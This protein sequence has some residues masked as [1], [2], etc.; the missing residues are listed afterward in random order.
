MFLMFSGITFILRAQNRL[1]R[2]LNRFESPMRHWQ[3][4]RNIAQESM[5]LLSASKPT[6]L[7][8]HESPCVALYHIPNVHIFGIYIYFESIIKLIAQCALD[9]HNGDHNLAAF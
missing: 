7:K 8:F 2:Y 3:P 9:R 4:V 6:M 1:K 5:R